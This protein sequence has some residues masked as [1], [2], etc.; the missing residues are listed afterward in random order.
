MQYPDHNTYRKLYAK[1]LDKRP[2]SMLV[3]LADVKDKSIV[4]LCCGE[5]EISK[6]CL[7]Q[8][9]SDIFMLDAEAEMID[10][11]SFLDKGGRVTVETLDVSTYL[12]HFQMTKLPPF[13]DVAFCRQAVNYWFLSDMTKELPCIIKPGGKFIFN[14]FNRKP[15]TTPA[16]KEYEYEGHQFVEISWLVPNQ[17]GSDIDMV[18]HV[19]IREEMLP[20]TTQFAWISREMFQE[21]LHRYFDISIRTDGG[22]DI[23]VCTRKAK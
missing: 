22:T 19:Q 3:N 1:Y 13:A 5:G 17:G 7:Q 10:L 23:Y 18:H 8:G 12:W 16:V 2:A 4:D 14:T 6:L 11:D 15:S 21:R 9:A 20:H